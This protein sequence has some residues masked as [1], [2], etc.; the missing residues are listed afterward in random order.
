[1]PINIDVDNKTPLG[2]TAKKNIETIVQLERQ[3]LL[4][5]TIAERWGDKMAHFFGSLCFIIVETFFIACWIFFNSGIG[6]F[7]SPFDPYPFP[8]LNL[9]VGMQFFFLTTFV[10]I[11]QKQQMRR[12]EQWSHLHLQLS[13]LGEQEITKELQTLHMISK[14]LGLKNVEDSLKSTDL[15]H[16]TPLQTLADEI[17]KTH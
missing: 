2:D 5:Q 7:F 10:L 15:T 9:I 11:N 12:M 16:E 13:I 17:E 3:L 4:K 1:M 8:F 14:E 6:A